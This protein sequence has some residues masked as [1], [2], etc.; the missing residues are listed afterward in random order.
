MTGDSPTTTTS[1][2]P[3]LKR[4]LEAAIVDGQ[5]SGDRDRVVAA[6]FVERHRVERFDL[7]ATDARRAQIFL[8]KLR[9]IR[10]DL[11]AAHAAAESRQAG[12]KKATSG[13]DFQHLIAGS[14]SS[15]CRNRPS[16]LGASINWPCPSGIWV[17]ANASSR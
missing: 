1:R 8:R 15:A 9:Q 3:I 5:R 13:A 12:R 4:A 6:R 11:E 10:E 16:T 17:S 14:S 7:H 2:P